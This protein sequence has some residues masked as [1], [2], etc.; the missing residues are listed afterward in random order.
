M[1]NRLYYDEDLQDKV[2]KLM[3]ISN[4]KEVIKR[5]KDYLG[6]DVKLY[7]STRKNKKYMVYNPENNQFVHFGSFSPPMEDFT[8]H[9]NEA[10]RNNYLKRAN[11]IKGN[12]KDNKF[13]PNNLSIHLLW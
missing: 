10:R 11:K 3:T 1:T 9:K 13:S 12:W 5:V 4:P 2:N 8:Y 7:V 6:N